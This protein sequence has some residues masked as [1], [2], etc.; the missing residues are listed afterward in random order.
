MAARD[1]GL[2]LPSFSFAFLMVSM[3]VFSPSLGLRG[4]A[5]AFGIDALVELAAR[6]LIW[7]VG[8]L[9]VCVLASV[10]VL[11]VVRSC[12]GSPLD[13]AV[14]RVG[15]ARVSWMPSPPTQYVGTGMFNALHTSIFL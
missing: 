2:D 3:V 7:S 6:S 9:G 5:V 11:V 8:C 1:G 14:A 12:E 4:S 13:E 15:E 10:F